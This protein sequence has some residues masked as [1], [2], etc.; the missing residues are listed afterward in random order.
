MT[1]PVIDAA[2][3]AIKHSFIVDNYDCGARWAR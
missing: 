1:N 2:V 3:L